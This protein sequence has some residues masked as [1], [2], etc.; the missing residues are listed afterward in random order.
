[1]PIYW[2]YTRKSEAHLLIIKW[3]KLHNSIVLASEWYKTVYISQQYLMILLLYHYIAVF[4]RRNTY[5]KLRRNL[6]TMKKNYNAERQ[7]Q[8]QQFRRQ[9]NNRYTRVVLHGH[10]RE[11]WPHEI[12]NTYMH[13]RILIF[14]SII[15]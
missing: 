9:V 13:V 15:S 14:V 12:I 10:R 3:L 5:Y 6:E 4:R 2:F 8:R 11:I 1:M 7:Q